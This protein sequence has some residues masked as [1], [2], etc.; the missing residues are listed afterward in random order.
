MGCSLGRYEESLLDTG[1]TLLK[2]ARETETQIEAFNTNNTPFSLSPA[3]SKRI[4][5]A[6]SRKFD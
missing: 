1:N 2:R 3:S 6:L 5:K 4:R